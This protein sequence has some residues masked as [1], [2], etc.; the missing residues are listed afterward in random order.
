MS[1]WAGRQTAFPALGIKTDTCALCAHALDGL[2]EVLC[3]VRT[4][5]GI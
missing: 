2:A 4:L 3:Y 1:P 5:Y